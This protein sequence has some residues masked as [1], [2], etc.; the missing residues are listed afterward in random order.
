MP[1]SPTAS[2]QTATSAIVLCGGASRRMGGVDKTR[3]LLG[4]STV[5]DRLLNTMPSCWDV[6]CVG[7]ERSTTR[8]VRWRRESPPGGGP[9]AG[10]AAGLLAVDSSVCVVVG[11][12][13]PFAATTLTLCYLTLEASPD[14]DGVLGVSPDGRTQPLLAAYRTAALR[15]AMPAVS[16]GARLMS[17]LDAMELGKVPCGPEAALDVDNP[18]ALKR[19]RH[20]VGT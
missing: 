12:D 10:I 4:A 16:R 13:M 11:G 3:S 6:V 20:I 1:L 9:V 7:E 2:S 19:A 5:L 8:A 18:E 15:R 14:D 17:L